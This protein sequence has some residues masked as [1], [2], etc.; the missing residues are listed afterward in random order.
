MS[1]GFWEYK[2]DTIRNLADD[3]EGTFV[4]RG[5]Y[6]TDDYSIP[7]EY[8][9]LYQDWDKRPQKEVDYL[10]GATDEQRE[11]LLKEIDSLV[12]EL[13]KCALRVKHLDWFLSGDTGVDSYIECLRKD[14]LL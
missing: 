14:N 4:K 2:Q 8:N 1:G 5:K 10:E 7:I 6:T 13:N 11:V 3:I 12:I 9:S